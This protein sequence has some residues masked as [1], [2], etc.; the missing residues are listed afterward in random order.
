MQAFRTKVT[1]SEDRELHLARVPFPPGCELEII[2]LE[3][4]V[5]SVEAEERRPD[6]RLLVQEQYRLAEDHPGEYVVLVGRR[7]VNH[8]PERREAL[9]AYRQAWSDFP[10]ERPVVVG[11]GGKPKQKPFFRGRALTASLKK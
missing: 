4:R 8:S 2:L 6:A 11:P 3:D 1:V 10:G 5:P 9:E 7:V